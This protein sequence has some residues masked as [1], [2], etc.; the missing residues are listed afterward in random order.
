MTVS[1]FVGRIRKKGGHIWLDELGRLNAEGISESQVEELRECY[2]LVVAVLREEVVGKRWEASGKDPNW[3]NYPE[4]RWIWPDQKL[5]PVDQ[6]VFQ[7]WLRTRC[8]ATRRYS[9]AVKFIFCAFCEEHWQ[10]VPPA[11]FLDLLEAAGF[12]VVDG[13]V[14]GLAL[15][16]DVSY[17]EKSHSHAESQQSDFQIQDQRG[18]TSLAS[19]RLS[20]ALG[21]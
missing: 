2:D 7:E 20:R 6:W 4:Y 19:W 17:W 11:R 14:D 13:F 9:S 15:G 8:S 18:W 3:W 10:E 5:R 21:A 16:S 1:Q 12:P